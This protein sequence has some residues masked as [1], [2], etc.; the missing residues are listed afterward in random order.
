MNHLKQEVQ[1]VH[2]HELRSQV[3]SF[4]VSGC[5]SLVSCPNFMALLFIS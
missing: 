2:Y 3:V 4:L 5:H 1:S